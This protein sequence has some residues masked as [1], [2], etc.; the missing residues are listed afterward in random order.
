MDFV[1]SRKKWVKYH[2]NAISSSDNVD[3]RAIGMYAGTASD[4]SNLVATGIGAHRRD[5]LFPGAA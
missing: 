3:G 5:F 1:S 2:K 4:G